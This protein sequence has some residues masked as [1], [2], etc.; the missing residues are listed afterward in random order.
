MDPLR[1]C[2]LPGLLRLALPMA[3]GA[4]LGYF[5]HFVNRL[6][7]SWH[8]SEALAASLPAG[9]LAWAGQC[10]FITSASYVGTF[11]AQH[12]GAQEPEEAGAMVYPM[13]WLALVAAVLSL[14]LIPFRHAICGLA[15]TEPGVERDMAALF[16]WTWRRPDRWR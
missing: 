6:F 3:L 1:S 4:G 14:A 16:A 13:A 11:A 7:L 2:S 10:F 15:G 5:M 8:S 9:M 12:L